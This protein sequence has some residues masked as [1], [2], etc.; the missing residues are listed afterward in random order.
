[1]PPLAGCSPELLLN[2]GDTRTRESLVAKAGFNSALTVSLADFFERQQFV[3][4][5][6]AGVRLLREMLTAR[7]S[8]S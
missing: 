2:V 5:D 6:N 1:M 3:P 7:S 8:Q 4:R